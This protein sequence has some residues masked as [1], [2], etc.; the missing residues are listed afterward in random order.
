ME[1]LILLAIG[2]FSGTIGSLVGLGGGIITVPAL[3]FLASIYPDYHEITPQVAVGTSLMLI[4]ITAL[5]SVFSYARQNRVDFQSGWVFFLGSGPGAIFGAYLTSYFNPREFH[6]GFG[7]LMIVVAGVLTFQNRLNFGEIRW[8][9]QREFQ[10]SEGNIYRYGYHYLTALVVSFFV[11][12]ISSLF[13]IGGGALIMPVM[14]LLFRF[15]AHVA[16]ATSMF[17]I[18]LS[19]IVGSTVHFFQGNIDWWAVIWI[20]PGA[21]LGG[22]LGA[23]LSNR[24]SSQGILIALRLMI[25]AVA[26]KMIV[27]GF[28]H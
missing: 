12:T 7:V 1:W 3:L 26:L 25:I 16:T 4:I 8:S 24:M 14:L 5:S 22:K 19:S 18:F 23:W 28:T 10:D 6:I 20:A 2:L 17:I 11:G 9:V 13:G 21:Y 27:D 15:P